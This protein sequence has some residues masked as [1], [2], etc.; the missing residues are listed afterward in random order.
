MT[1]RGPAF[2]QTKTRRKPGERLNAWEFVE[3]L[4]DGPRA[5]LR[6]WLLRCACGWERKTW[7]SEIKSLGG[8][9]T[10]CANAARRAKAKEANHGEA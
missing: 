9:C 8:S 1:A 3:L 2:F 4:E 6:R 7:E 10:G 5:P